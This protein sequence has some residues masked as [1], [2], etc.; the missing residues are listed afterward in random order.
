VGQHQCGCRVYHKP[1]KFAGTVGSILQ[2][3]NATVR[4]AKVV[5][6]GSENFFLDAKATVLHEQA[7]YQLL[8]LPAGRS[9]LPTHFFDCPQT[10][11]LT[12]SY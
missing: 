3:E 12:S 8:A 9:A 10:G 6:Y 2:E 11:L 1:P 4:V 7:G 5:C